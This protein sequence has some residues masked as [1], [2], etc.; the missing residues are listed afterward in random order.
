MS[1]ATNVT[2]DDIER[3]ENNHDALLFKLAGIEA[4]TQES[5][6]GA[7]VDRLMQGEVPLIVWREYRGVSR[8]ALAE[9]SGVSVA[10]IDAV[11]KHG[12]DLGLRKMVALAKAL[13]LDAEDL[14]AWLEP[15]PA[16]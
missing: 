14:L 16:N 15:A 3:L 12:A 8:E 10:D 1:N 4:A 9:A 2:A 13:R 11:E 7:V 6:P 5:V